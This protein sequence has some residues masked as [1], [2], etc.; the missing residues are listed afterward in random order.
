MG[1]R[2][3]KHELI[4]VVI[5]VSSTSS[6]FYLPDLPNLRNVHLWNLA[7]YSF[8]N[9]PKSIISGLPVIPMALLRSCFL[10]LQTYNGKNFCYQV[11][12]IEFLTLSNIVVGQ[13]NNYQPITFAGQKIN[14]P[15]SYI[16]IADTTLISTTESQ[17]ILLGDIY[18]EIKEI[19]K[20]DAEANFR[21]QS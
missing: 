9:T 6:K 12:L 19:A 11:P 1:K 21:N 2:L 15:K 17:V 14:Y 18:S 8:L 10:T 3:F 4:E 16:E 5:P 7:T 13:D 20:K